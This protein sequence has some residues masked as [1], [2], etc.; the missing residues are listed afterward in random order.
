M[1][2]TDG[3]PPPEA[4]TLTMTLEGALGATAKS[5]MIMKVAPG[6]SDPLKVQDT[7]VIWQVAPDPLMLT[8]VS[9]GARF[10]TTAMVPLVAVDELTLAIVTA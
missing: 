3:E 1:A 4:W 7:E 10:T 9:E 6:A 2:V 8:G 5:T